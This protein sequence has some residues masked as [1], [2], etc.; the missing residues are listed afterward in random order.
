MA[1]EASIEVNIYA[2]LAVPAMQFLYYYSNS[3]MH[4]LVNKPSLSITHHLP[5]TN[6]LLQISL[7]ELTIFCHLFQRDLEPA[8]NDENY[9]L[10]FLLSI[11]GC[12]R[13]DKPG[14]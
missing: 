10:L 12:Y 6:A 11:G 14:E 7:N 8:T 13:R 3:C 2:N 1:S 4:L 5:M 9:R